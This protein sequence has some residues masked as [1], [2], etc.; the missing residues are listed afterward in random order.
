MLHDLAQAHAARVRADGDALVGG[1]QQDRDVLV[2]AGHAARVDLEDAQRLRVEELLEHDAALAVL[3]GRDRDRVDAAL[4]LRV[5]QDV[6]RAGGLLD[7]V[8]VELRE[9]VDPVDRL[10]HVPAL[11]RVDGDGEALA[12]DL[13]GDAQTSDVV[14][15]VRAHLELDLAEALVDR[16]AAQAGQLLVA[17]AQPARRGRVGG[18]ALRAQTGDALLAALRAAAQDLK[19]VLFRHD[20]GQVAE[21]DEVEDLLRR[22]L[23]QE[24][25]ERESGALGLEVPERVDDRADRHVHDALLRAQP[26]QLRVVDELAPEAAHVVEDG[27]DVAAAQR[28]GQGLDRGGLDVVAAAD[29]EDEAVSLMVVARIR[30]D[31]QVGGGVVGIRVHRVGPVEVPRGGESDVVDVDADDGAHASLLSKLVRFPH[32]SNVCG[33]FNG[34]HSGTRVVRS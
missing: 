19:R 8:D 1:Q 17:V 7:P 23:R 31:H 27:L 28:R 33:S 2:D 11:V 12:A 4:D 21:V 25:P 13:A 30:A 32:T 18:V 29:R 3:A 9:V 24:F 26:A 14:L 10:G 16:L 15:A 6:V 5:G 34:S 22:H 20:V